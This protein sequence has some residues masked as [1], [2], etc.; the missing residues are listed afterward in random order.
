LILLTKTFKEVKIINKK[1]GHSYNL[2][3]KQSAKFFYAKNANGE[4]IN[5]KD[6]YSIEEESEINDIQFYL[7]T[8]ALIGLSIASFI[9]YIQ[10]N[11]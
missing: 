11:Y 2:S 3:P 5:S 7:L 1:S 4:Y 10:W 6:D 9:L 8:F